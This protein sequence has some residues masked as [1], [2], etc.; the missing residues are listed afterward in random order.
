M[1]RIGKVPVA[2]PDKVKIKVEKGQVLVEGPK[3]KLS[4]DIHPRVKVEAKEKE[5]HLTK[6]GV[7]RGTNLCFGKDFISLAH[8]NDL[9]QNVIS[10]MMESRDI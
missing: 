5:V 9:Y 10:N 3:G 8:V 2:I 1:S 4:Q 7:A 6:L